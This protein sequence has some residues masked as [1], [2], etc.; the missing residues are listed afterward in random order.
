MNRV[1]HDALFA[2][3]AT[4]LALAFSSLSVAQN[5]IDSNLR[6]GGG[7]INPAA[8][9]PNYRARNMLITN[10]VLGGRGFREAVGYTAEA[11]FRDD[12]GSND[13]YSFRRDSAWSDV[14]YVNLG[15][16]YQRFRY[17]Q[18]LGLLEYRRSGSG[19]TAQTLS[20]TIYTNP[21][22]QVRARM[23]LD[24]LNYA[25]STTIRAETANQPAIIGFA[26]NTEGQTYTF[27]TSSL[28]GLTSVP[29]EQDT[30]VLGLSA[31][32]LARARE[33]A[34][35]GREASVLGRPFRASYD[36]LVE[37][38]KT[39]I[40]SMRRTLREPETMQTLVDLTQ[41]PEFKEILEHVAERY[42]QQEEIDVEARPELLQGLDARLNELRS[43]LARM[44][45]AADAETEAIMPGKTGETRPPAEEETGIRSPFASPDDEESL[46]YVEQEEAE[47]SPTPTRQIDPDTIG[48]VLR[49]GQRIDHLTGGKKD[50]TRFY[51]LM[52]RAEEHLRSGEYF[53]AERGFNSALRFTP[54]HPMATAGLAHSQIGAGLYLSAA[55]TLRGLF[56]FQP[57]MI[58]ASYEAGLIPDQER[59]L[60]AITTLEQRLT[61]E[62][63]R[64]NNAFLLAYIGNLTK[65]RR[66]VETGLAAMAESLPKDPMPELL[67]AIWL[68]VDDGDE[69]PPAGEADNDA[70][71][72]D[73]VEPEK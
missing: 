61:L 22:E 37:A 12:L 7:Q 25:S 68:A 42:A 50:L 33:D 40:D 62:R 60:T 58:D 20:E 38:N 29:V 5:A 69:L 1:R 54:G 70:S 9:Q 73:A 35:S 66:I 4:G 57:E 16:T 55:L 13:L 14:N 53:R 18:D 10:S 2:V 39:Q 67:R 21:G 51:E 49:H 31:F 26:T 24:R 32:D 17:G 23:Q 48:E 56:T 52:S 3:T 44:E 6:V 8:A 64:G 59:L 19:S 30:N 47:D 36:D 28:Q 43:N 46:S 71:P 65:D 11:D 63:Q 72:P 15:N 27:N 45:E 34:M 41:E